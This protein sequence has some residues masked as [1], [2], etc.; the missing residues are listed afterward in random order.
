ME[1]RFQQS[2]NPSSVDPYVAAPEPGRHCA[3]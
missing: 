2:Y 3:C 1:A